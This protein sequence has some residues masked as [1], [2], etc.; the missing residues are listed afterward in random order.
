[1]TANVCVHLWNHHKGYKASEVWRRKLF[2]HPIVRLCKHQNKCKTPFDEEEQLFQEFQ[3]E[4]KKATGTFKC[5]RPIMVSSEV[6][7]FKQE[8]IELV[9]K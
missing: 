4:C 2:C 6:H 5:E 7:Q 1:M 8:S 9:E 3:Q